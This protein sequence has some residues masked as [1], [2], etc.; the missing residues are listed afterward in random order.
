VHKVKSDPRLDVYV[1]GCKLEQVDWLRRYAKSRAYRLAV[2]SARPA[3][4]VVRTAARNKTLHL[5]WPVRAMSGLTKVFGMR[6]ACWPGTESSV[7]NCRKAGARDGGARRQILVTEFFR[8]NDGSARAST[9][10]G[11]AIGGLFRRLAACNSFTAV[12]FIQPG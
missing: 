2:I 12:E 11:S 9:V 8:I 4:T 7:S 1:R 3:Q 5:G 10:L 6:R